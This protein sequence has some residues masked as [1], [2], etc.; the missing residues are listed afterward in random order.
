[1]STIRKMTTKSNNVLNVTLLRHFISINELSGYCYRW[2]SDSRKK[3]MVHFRS[4]SLKVR[5]GLSFSN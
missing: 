3:E 5:M 4:T 2:K 1:M